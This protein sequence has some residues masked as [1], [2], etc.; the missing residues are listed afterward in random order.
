[1]LKILF[2][3]SDSLGKITVSIFASDKD[4]NRI[5]S[6]NK[7]Q[8]FYGWHFKAEGLKSVPK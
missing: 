5:P 1:V 8:Q 6:T 7:K 4:K 3:S 2:F